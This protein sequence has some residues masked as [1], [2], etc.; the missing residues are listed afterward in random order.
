MKNAEE[1]NDLVY[2]YNHL[3]EAANINSEKGGKE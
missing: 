3:L 1:Y 2:K